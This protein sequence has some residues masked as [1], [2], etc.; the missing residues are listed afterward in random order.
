MFSKGQVIFAILFA[1]TFLII[2][3]RSYRKDR[4][5][6]QKNFK[7]VRWV[8][9]GFITFVIILFIIKYMLNNEA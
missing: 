9:F 7:G 4:N 8:A 3:V 6:H 2:I 5:L 1:V